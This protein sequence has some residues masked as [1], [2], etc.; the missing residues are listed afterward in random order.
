MSE[1]QTNPHDES[2]QEANHT[3]HNAEPVIRSE[4]HEQAHSSGFHDHND[5]SIHAPHSAKTGTD[6]A[7]RL[8]HARQHA[9]AQISRVA[10]APAWSRASQIT[11]T[12]E[13]AYHDGHLTHPAFVSIAIL[14]FAAF[15]SNFTQLQLTSA[16]PSIDKEFGIP[17]VTGQWMTSIF[18]LVMGVMVP[19]TA[20]FTQR[21][22]TRQ[23]VIS[24]MALFTIGSVICWL[25]PLFPLEIVGR[26][27]EAMGGGVMWPVL[28]IVV[29]STIPITHRGQAM[30]TV[31][32]AMAVAPAIGPTIGGWQTDVNGWRSI[33]LTLAI[34]GATT[35]VLCVFLLRNFMEKNA[36]IHAD[37][38]SAGLSTLGMGGLLYGFTNIEA[39]PLTSPV[40]WAPMLL[41]LVTSIWFVVRQL[42]QAVPLLNLRVLKNRAFTT[43]TVIA[44]LSYFAFSSIILM[45]SQYIQNDRGYSA[46]MAG[47]IILPGAF[48]TIISQFFSGR[49]LDRLGARPVAIFGTGMLLIGTIMMS[50]I[51]DNTNVWWISI[52]QF[53]RQ[54][55]MGAT[56]MPI[57]TWALNS[58]SRE[59]MSDGSATTNT[60]R[61]IAG[62]IGSPVLIVTLTSLTV[63]RHSQGFGQASANIWATRM[64]LIIS[65]SICAVM[66]LLA[67]FGV[68]GAGAGHI[69]TITLDQLRR[70]R[71][72]Q[73][74]A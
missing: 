50:F 45:L 57:T 31:G 68:K 14:T 41:G 5:H 52:S 25:S 34:I 33:F 49:F 15:L 11:L 70:Q 66:F 26:V 27:L 43:G 54:I 1:E 63:W 61:Q 6:W 48:G 51:S 28:Q 10:H 21:F 30:G 17:L 69:H 65:A 59:D 74:A 3:T 19:L 71:K 73:E 35:M 46:T 38:F 72:Q 18:Q 24:S 12:R 13:R 2:E 60:I 44:S 32:I 29:F 42:R 8:Y 58:L 4:R 16:L 55:G 39:Y 23:I 62:A 36:S 9:L 37:F 7:H 56:L 47:L 22:S 64:T 40:C 67:V 20:F 53:V